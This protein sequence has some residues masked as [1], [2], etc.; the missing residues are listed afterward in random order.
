MPRT[1][2]TQSACILLQG[3]HRKAAEGLDSYHVEPLT[4][5]PG[6]IG[7]DPP[8]RWCA[9]PAGGNMGNLG[10]MGRN[11]PKGLHPS[12]P[13]REGQP[14]PDPQIRKPLPTIYTLDQPRTT[15]F[16]RVCGGILSLCRGQTYLLHSSRRAGAFDKCNMVLAMQRPRLRTRRQDGG[17]NASRWEGETRA[18]G[19]G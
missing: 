18:K 10:N 13:Y 4:R 17:Q 7:Q 6:P 14:I 12:H 1:H 5:V 19:R 11:R 16:D 9:C 2:G 8:R 3:C 15:N